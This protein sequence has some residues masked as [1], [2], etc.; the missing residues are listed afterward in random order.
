MHWGNDQSWF[1][2]RVSYGPGR[3]SRNEQRW[4][5]MAYPPPESLSRLD[6]HERVLER[7]RVKFQITS[8][9]CAIDPKQEFLSLH[10][11]RKD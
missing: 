2:R 11:N 9:N 8:Q 3:Q 4:L 10:T 1:L 7:R 6:V 5:T